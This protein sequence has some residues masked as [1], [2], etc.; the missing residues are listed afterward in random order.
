MRRTKARTPGL[1]PRTNPHNEVI[2]WLTRAAPSLDLFGHALC[3]IIYYI[4]E[5]TA[6]YRWKCFKH[7][8][9]HTERINWVVFTFGKNR[10][11]RIP[12]LEI[13]IES[14]SVIS[15]QSAI[16][17]FGAPPTIIIQEARLPLCSSCMRFAGS[18]H[19]SAPTSCV[20][21]QDGRATCM[22]F[23]LVTSATRNTPVALVY[24]VYSHSAL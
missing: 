4:M 11:P 15:G 24:I 5:Q 9:I 3:L 21:T 14:Q 17:Q 23:S 18:A 1:F 13:V 10:L 16:N 19:E 22:S 20:V 8:H 6:R 7:T 12:C 2:K